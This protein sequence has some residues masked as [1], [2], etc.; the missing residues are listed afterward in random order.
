MMNTTAANGTEAAYH[1]VPAE[2]DYGYAQA[3]RSETRSMSPAS[4]ATTTRGP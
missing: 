3:S 1:V 2:D 4:S